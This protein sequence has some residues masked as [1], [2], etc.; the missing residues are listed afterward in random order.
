MVSE[1]ADANILKISEP[2]V[3]EGSNKFS[4]IERDHVAGFTYDFLLFS[5]FIYKYQSFFIGLNLR[6]Y[7]FYI[8]LL[9]VVFAAD[10]A[11]C[12]VYC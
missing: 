8:L 1:P 12:N 11:L 7:V 4:I 6:L 3:T 5:M 10:C 9:C 2:T